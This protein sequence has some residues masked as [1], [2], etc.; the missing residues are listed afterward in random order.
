MKAKILQFQT[1]G[2][3]MSDSIFA[4]DLGTFFKW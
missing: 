1:G 3:S 2:T 4:K